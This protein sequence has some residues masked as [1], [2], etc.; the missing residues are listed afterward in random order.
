VSAGEIASE[1]ILDGDV[2][3]NVEQVAVDGA[4]LL[5]GS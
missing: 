1:I 2:V 5:D 3:E 4:V